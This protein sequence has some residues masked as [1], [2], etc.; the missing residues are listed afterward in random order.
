MIM[1]T[2][3]SQYLEKIKK[4][5]NYY[6]HDLSNEQDYHFIMDILGGEE[7]V[8]NSSPELFDIINQL[9]HKNVQKRLQKTSCNAGIP[10]NEFENSA[11]IRY[12]N[13]NTQTMLSTA[14]SINLNKPAV[15]L[16]IVGELKDLTSGKSVAGYSVFG[17]DQNEL[18]AQALY[19]SE[20]L[21]KS[22]DKQFQA[23]STFMWI[24]NDSDSLD[25]H[26][27]TEVSDVFK[28]NNDSYI[29]RQLSVD[30]PDTIHNPKR[31]HTVIVYDR[32]AQVSEDFDYEFKLVSSGNE[33]EIKIPFKGS[34][35]L[36]PPFTPK[37]VDKNQNFKLQIEHSEFGI[38]SFDTTLWDKIKWSTENNRLSWQF[39]DDWGMTL[40]KKNFTYGLDFKLYCRMEIIADYA[41]IPFPSPIPIV[42]SCDETQGGDPSYKMV[43]PIDIWW[44]CFAKNTKIYK[45]DGSMVAIDN[46]Q[47]G[48]SI[49]TWQNGDQR[50][51]DIISG[52]ESQLVRIEL[53]NGQTIS[54][55][56]DHPMLSKR[57]TIRARELSA[58][59]ILCYG[60]QEEVAIQYIYPQKYDDIVYNIKL[61]CSSLI[62][63]NGFVAGDFMT[64][65]SRCSR[66][67]S[68]ML[69]DSHSKLQQEFKELIKKLDSFT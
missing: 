50:I 3:D 11:K 12:I 5:G 65:Q 45:A 32:Q 27:C 4:N 56:E 18:I 28:I 6:S 43:K 40:N 59:D 52:F 31:A 67:Q 68:A 7:V 66:L 17:K 1:K 21:S 37:Y 69:Q 55:T 36:T 62:F 26:S 42:I 24:T 58:A 2:H 20:K 53:I 41:G 33:V 48:D 15:T 61:E 16:A 60:N 34:V 47:I 19:E 8:K 13:Y 57:G 64:Q 25:F 23:I 35:E 44:G 29:V 49:M 38:K 22:S 46:L 51:V 14:S 39:P 30:D 9:R 54:V 10:T 63:A